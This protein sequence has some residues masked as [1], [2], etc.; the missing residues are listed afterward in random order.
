MKRCATWAV[1]L[2]LVL[3]MFPF[4]ILS[5]A[6]SALA[7]EIEYSSIIQSKSNQRQSGNWIYSIM[8]YGIASIDGYEGNATSL[9]IP[10]EIDGYP[11]GAIGDNA[12]STQTRLTSVTIPTQVFSI[13]SG[14]FYNPAILTVT[15]YDG[16]T[17]LAW[18]ENNGAKVNSLTDMYLNSGI[19]DL[20]GVGSG[21]KKTGSNTLEVNAA[22]S[23]VLKEGT[24]FFFTATD[25]YGQN[26][27]GGQVTGVQRRDGSATVS[28][29]AVEARVLI[30]KV[31]A[32]SDME[33]IKMEFI[34][35]PDLIVY[36]D[37]GEEVQASW[38]DWEIN[39]WG[40][41]WGE[42][43]GG[44]SI[45]LINRTIK[46]FGVPVTL[47][48]DFD[49]DFSAYY[50]YEVFG[51]DRAS[52]SLNFT[53]T[54]TIK[55]HQEAVNWSGSLNLGEI[56]IFGI[57]GFGLTVPVDLVG[58]AHVSIDIDIKDVVSLNWSFDSKYNSTPPQPVPVH[59]TP[60]SK[61]VVTGDF[62]VGLAIGLALKLCDERLVY[63]GVEGGV[64]IYGKATIHSL[65]IDKMCVDLQLRLYIQANVSCILLGS[66]TFGPIEKNLWSAHYEFDSFSPFVVH[67]V[68]VC[69]RN[70]KTIKLELNGGERMGV[71]SDKQVEWGSTFS[72]GAPTRAK[73]TFKGWYT[74]AALTNQWVNESRVY[75]DM[76]LYAKWE[77][78]YE[79]VTNIR[80]NTSALTIHSSG[81]D[82]TAKLTATISPSDA[83]NKNVKWSSSDKSVATVS[84]TGVVTGIAKGQA[85]ITATSA[86]NA[87]KKA[88]CVVTVQQYVDRINVTAANSAPLRLGTTQVSA[89]VL[90]DNANNKNYTWSSNNTNVATVNASGVVTARNVG[91][92]VITA[93]AQDG[94]GVTGS[95]TINVQPIPVASVSVSK[96]TA[97]VYTSGSSKTL[98]LSASILPTNA[99]DQ[100]VTWESNKP[101]IAGVDAS[102]KVTGM[103]AGTAVI[104]VRS[105]F[106]P[107]IY[108]QCTVTVKQLVTRLTLNKSSCE[109][110]NNE[111]TQL[112]VTVIPSDATNKSV[113]W[114]SS[115]PNVVTVSETG[116]V[117]AV[118]G[119]DAMISVIAKDGSLVISQCLVHVNG[120]AAAPVVPDP[121]VSVQ[122]V[123]LDFE[124]IRVFTAGATKSIQLHAYVTPAN[125]G[126]PGIVWSSSNSAVA[127]VDSTGKVTGVK[128]GN[129][130]ITAKSAANNSITATCSVT[131]EQLAESITLNKT[132]QS[133]LKGEETVQLTGTVLPTNATNRNIKWVSSDTG[134][135]V[136]DYTG[137]VSGVGLGNAVISAE[138]VD[139]SGV[140]ASFNVTVLP[141][142]VRSVTLNTSSA[143]AYT[144]GRDH[145]IQLT[146]QALP[147]HAEDRSLT[148]SSSNPAVA[149]VD[150]DGKVTGLTQGT[151]VITVKSVSNPEQKD[152]CSV[153]VKT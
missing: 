45:N 130:V 113:R 105:H 66:K 20:S 21:A 93:T 44:K 73:Y 41:I 15:G 48:S 100:S 134:I 76:T 42:V 114:V 127:T 61:I 23:Y 58:S 34:P 110:N 9:K 25:K 80:L 72:I 63:V 71:F 86:D 140:T 79:P 37:A 136:V 89:T 148:W 95:V 99:D 144:S 77:R 91:T 60:V 74:D 40:D 43:S 90:P 141:V 85:T 47:R 81:S 51:K 10:V 84:S 149:T 19:V 2:V 104:T 28:F 22:L 68:A 16:S 67:D 92:A 121:S 129:A 118:G 33:G 7:S 70:P 132:S 57:K 62:K 46:F 56:L 75:N 131:V 14:A 69:T 30:D 26:F 8:N 109:L 153:T 24:T 126:N 4:W 120:E 122:S 1:V 12:F 11:V 116:L 135:A 27:W 147:V 102:G 35:N 139:G 78:N 6:V 55:A 3:S 106:N 96:K 108:D 52:A 17:G 83:T 125:A 5:P 53:I 133:I 128:G 18:A 142:P 112:S 87:N 49:I 115:N 137:L 124:A 117:T 65:L 150:A 103:C 143:T 146:A 98:Q 29:E 119:G 59:N 13:G 101:G 111:T 31:I 138:A 88:S 97:E 107:S 38:L 54:T 50:D 152:T 39:L 145:E 32:S 82:R 36:N 64:H 151:A 94:S 123:A